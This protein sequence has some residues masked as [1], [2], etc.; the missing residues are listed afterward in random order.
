MLDLSMFSGPASVEPAKG[1]SG[2]PVNTMDG[3][4][5][6]LD[7]L[8]PGAAPSSKAGIEEWVRGLPDLSYMLSSTLVLTG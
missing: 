8:V 3:M 7:A 1:T 4:L 5:A 2:S 6:S